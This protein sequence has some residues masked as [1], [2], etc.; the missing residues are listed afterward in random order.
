MHQLNQL[1]Q[2]KIM[3]D[4]Q[5]LAILRRLMV[6]PATLSQLGGF[7]KETPAHIRHHL[8][9]LEQAGFV[10]LA[11]LNVVHNLCEKYYRASSS[12]YQINLVILP[13]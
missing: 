11:S 3:G 4:Y 12:A 1:H 9:V 7:F 6:S 2:I 10:E 8:K 5:R 13:E